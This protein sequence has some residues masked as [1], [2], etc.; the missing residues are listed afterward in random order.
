[1]IRTTLFLAL[2]A[3]SSITALAERPTTTSPYSYIAQLGRV[4]FGRGGAAY[5][6]TAVIK[7][8]ISP[9]ISPVMQFILVNHLMN[10]CVESARSMAPGK[11]ES[12]GSAKSKFTYG[13]CRL[14]HCFEQGLLLT[15]LARG[16]DSQDK[17][18]QQ[19]KAAILASAFQSQGGCDGSSSGIDS[20]LVQA[21]TQN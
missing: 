4:G 1:M 13:V 5:L 17:A 14:Q 3:F 15:A 11:L 18:G 10:Q 12:Y 6:P 16:G 2:A 8:Q 7:Q 19:Q 21:A 9:G 20:A